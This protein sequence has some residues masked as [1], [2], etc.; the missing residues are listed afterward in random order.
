[1]L[2]RA[3]LHAA[4]DFVHH[5]HRDVLDQVDP[6]DLVLAEEAED[7][8]MVKAAGAQHLL[9]RVNVIVPAPPSEARAG[10]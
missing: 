9:G 7:L 8:G 3:N 1:V 6:V 4:A 2:A 5:E 10:A